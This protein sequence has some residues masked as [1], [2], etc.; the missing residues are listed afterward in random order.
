MEITKFKIEEKVKSEPL[1]TYYVF[2]DNESKKIFITSKKKLH[3]FTLL[4]V[5]GCEKVNLP[6]YTKDILPSIGDIVADVNGL[7]LK[8]LTIDWI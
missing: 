7:V 4:Y 1:K 5:I 2:G 8:I 6:L 3:N